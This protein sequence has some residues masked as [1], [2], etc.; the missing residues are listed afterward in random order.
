MASMSEAVGREKAR[1]DGSTGST[2]GQQINEKHQRYIFDAVF[3]YYETPLPLQRGRGVHLYDF[4]GNEYLDFFA[5]IV[6]V[7]VGH[8]HPRVTDAIREQAA[9]LQHVSTLYPTAPIVELAEKLA[10]ITPG[11]LGKTYFTNSGT[12]ANETAV[13]LAQLATGA[14]TIVA[15]RHSYSGR[16]TVA[17]SLSGQAPWK[18]GAN[19]IAAVVHAPAPYCYRCPFKL[20]YPECG[21]A[22]A[23]DLEELIATST[24]GVVAGFLAET[25]LGAGGYIV[26]PAEYFPV[27]VDIIRRHG[28]LFIADE[29]Q[30]GFG[31]TGGRWFGIEHWDVEPDVIT[32]AKGIANGAPL[33]ATVT[34]PELADEFGGGLSISTFGGNPMSSVASLASIAVIEEEGLLENAASVGAHLRH[35]LDELAERFDIIGDVRGMGLMQGIELV[36]DRDSKEPAADEAARLMEETK[37]RGLLVGKGGL[38]GNVLR[39]GPPLNI[40]AGQVDEGVDMLSQSFSA[41]A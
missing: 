2:R 31:R 35:R 25:V 23:E 21:V 32:M 41:L 9:T 7:N 17:R 33:G 16:S 3:N 15:L 6:T 28:G 40:S 38:Y 5:G 18:M 1:R 30:S 29:V 11:D 27:A 37:S 12:E 8:C 39:I 20:T 14:Q 36:R 4:D 26:P 24:P 13:L 19:Q 34:R 22:C 10:H